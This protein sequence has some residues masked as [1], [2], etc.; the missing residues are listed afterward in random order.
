MVAYQSTV[1]IVSIDVP[2]G[3]D[4]S[5][6]D[7]TSIGLQPEC[8]ISLT[9]PKECA[10]KFKGRYHALGG[11]FMNKSVSQTPAGFADAVMRAREF[12]GIEHSSHSLTPCIRRLCAFLSRTLLSKYNIQLPPYPGS[13]QFMDISTMHLIAAKPQP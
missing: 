5:D 1:P 13:A 12:E 3:W 9:A 10:R 11:R 8:L 4:V 2:S 7:I 6:G